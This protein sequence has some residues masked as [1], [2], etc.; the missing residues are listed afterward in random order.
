MLPWLDPGSPFPPLERALRDPNGLLAAGGDLSPEQLLNAYQQGIFP[1]FSDGD[2]I[3][4]WSPD[5]RM[6]LVPDDFRLSRSLRKRLC[7]GDFEV[8]TDTAFRA[9][10]GAC[11]S[12]PR[13]GQ[14]GTW[15]VE[16]IIDAYSALHELGVAHSVESWQTDESG[17]RRLVGGLYG[18][19]LGRMFY[20]ES[21]FS[22]ATD[23]SKAAFA[24]LVR[25]LGENAVGLIDC[26]MKTEHLASLG[27]A[28]IPRRDFSTQLKRLVAQPAFAWPAGRWNF[29][30]HS[31]WRRPARNCC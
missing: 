2:P 12:V 18:V 22:L 13:P 21:M 14:N 7:R 16:D 28:E 30:W 23:A 11:A 26:Q 10:M 9:V 15:I 24:H 3:L 17:T 31:D 19:C 4:W 8:C 5:P 27:A 6:V 1:W 20:G 25:W 29:D